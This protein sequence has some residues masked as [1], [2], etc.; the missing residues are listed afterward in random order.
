MSKLVGLNLIDPIDGSV[1]PDSVIEIDHGIVRSLETGFGESGPFA[2]MFAIPGLIDGHVHLT[3][4]GGSSV[5]TTFQEASDDDLVRLALGN[6]RTAAKAGVTLV[7]DCGWPRHL[8]RVLLEALRSDPLLPDVLSSGAPMT[9]LGGHCHF[10]G[11]E[12]ADPSDAL[13]LVDELADSGSDWLKVMVTGGGLT[14]GTRPQDVELSPEI[15]GVAINR[16]RTIG[17]GVAAHCHSLEGLRY[18]IDL[19]V[20]TVEH[21]TMLDEYGKPALDVALIERAA[22]SGVAFG[23]TVWGA[24]K[25]AEGIRKSGPINPNDIHALERLDS[26]RSNVA[27]F[28]DVGVAMVAG[29]DAGATGTAFDSLAFELRCYVD[30]GLTPLEAIQTATTSAANS[31]RLPER[32]RVAPGKVADIV[33]L[34]DNPLEDISRIANPVA[35]FRRGQEVRLD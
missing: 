6:A 14:P 16:A 25:T 26:R 10:F 27:A 15:L 20:D 7:R 30:A 19:G 4:D 32:G 31:L 11:G 9:R 12:V 24:Y 3:L 18:C 21:V 2:G 33:V 34:R 5:R 28:H 17:L 29:T 23:P 1:L 13:R 22:N 8:S 35:V